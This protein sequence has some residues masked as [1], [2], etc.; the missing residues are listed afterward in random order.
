MNKIQQQ[1]VLPTDFYHMQPIDLSNPN[2]RHI[3]MYRFTH[4]G[5]PFYAPMVPDGICR[6]CNYNSTNH[7]KYYIYSNYARKIQLVFFKYKFK[8]FYRDNYNKFRSLGRSYL[9]HHAAV[10]KYK[11]LYYR[12]WSI[13]TLENF[14]NSNKH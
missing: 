13:W 7:R 5:C 4:L 2:F 11:I 12:K 9:P 8:K 14:I 10:L 6:L 1:T 3:M